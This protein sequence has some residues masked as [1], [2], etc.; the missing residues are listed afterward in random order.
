[1]FGAKFSRYKWTDGSHEVI[2][3]IGDKIQ[4]QNG[5]GAMQNHIYFCDID[6]NTREVVNI[7]VV[8]GRI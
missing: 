1:V 6:I 5:F 4:F 2:T 7:R 8:A 3:A